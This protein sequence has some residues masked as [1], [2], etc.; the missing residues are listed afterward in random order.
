MLF[1]LNIFFPH[2]KTVL[3][4]DAFTKVVKSCFLGI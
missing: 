4:Q 3:N 2:I 1:L